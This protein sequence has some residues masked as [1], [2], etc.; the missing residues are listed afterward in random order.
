VDHLCSGALTAWNDKTEGTRVRRG[1]Q[2]V[3]TCSGGKE[4]RQ[5][6]DHQNPGGNNVLLLIAGGSFAA[7]VTSLTPGLLDNIPLITQ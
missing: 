2:G 7:A 3:T 6:R 1:K 5:K 4:R